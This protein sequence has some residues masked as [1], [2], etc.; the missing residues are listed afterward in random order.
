LQLL[1]GD[2]RRRRRAAL[3]DVEQQTA[4]RHLR[5]LCE[6]LDQVLGQVGD[7]V[8]RDHAQAAARLLTRAVAIAAEL[9]RRLPR[10]PGESNS[11]SGRP[12]I[13]SLDEVKVQRSLALVQAL[14]AELDRAARGGTTPE[15]PELA[16]RLGTQ[17]NALAAA[18]AS[19]RLSVVALDGAGS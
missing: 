13:D 14:D 7:A 5:T 19:G 10:S 8:R 16:G 1:Q 11:T 9:A 3:A 6:D 12:V 18:A 17:I 15:A 4:R 2:D